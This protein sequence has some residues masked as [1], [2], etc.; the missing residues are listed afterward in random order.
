[1]ALSAG[2]VAALGAGASPLAVRPQSL[3]AYWP[4]Y[5]NVSP[6]TD[7]ISGYDMTLYNSPTEADSHPPLSFPINMWVSP[8]TAAPEAEAGLAGLPAWVLRGVLRGA[9]RGVT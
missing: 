5:G 6:E 8:F 3:V 7:I 9:Y 4:L 2:E 1:V